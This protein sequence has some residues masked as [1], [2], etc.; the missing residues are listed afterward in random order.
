MGLALD[1]GF[2]DGG[3][4][5]YASVKKTCII[6]TVNRQHYELQQREKPSVWRL[7]CIGGQGTPTEFFF[8][9]IGVNANWA[10]K[11]CQIHDGLG[12]KIHV[13]GH[14]IAQFEFTSIFG[15][16]VW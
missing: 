15:K 5:M 14:F 10:I 1:G 13:L 16:K 3:T 4:Q 8:Q 7:V 11:Y 2:N 12:P 6:V 9:N